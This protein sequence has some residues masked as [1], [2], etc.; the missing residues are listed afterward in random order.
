M[1][2]LRQDIA[3]SLRVLRANPGFTTVAVLT[4]A[5]GIGANAAIFS[6]V[7]AALLRPLPFREPDRLMTASL[8]MPVQYGPRVIDMTWSYP[9]SRTFREVQRAFADLSLHRA[10]ALTVGGADGAERVQG[11]IVEASYFRILGVD[12]AHGRLFA[13]EE[14]TPAGGAP[15]ALISDAYWRRRFS[16]ELGVLGSRI[17]VNGRP[18]TVV[19]VLPRGFRG[20]S[21]NSDL[22]APITSVRSRGVLTGVTTHQ[23][24]MIARLRPLITAGQAKEAVRDAG[25][26]VDERHPD[27]DR[28]RWRAAAYTMSEMRVD[29]AL[30][31]SVLTLGLAVA[32]VLLIACANIANL[33][34][35]RGAARHREIAVRLA[36]GASRGRLVR[37]LLTE[38]AVLAVL[39]AVAGLAVAAIGV[40]VLAASVPASAG[41]LAG[42]VE[43]EH[44]GLTRVALSGI[45]LD[46]SVLLFTLGVTIVTGLLFGLAPAVTASRAPLTD[47]MRQGHVAAPAF[48][49]LR[50]LTGRGALVAAE[51][52]LAVVLLVTAG[53]MIKSLGRLFETHV[54]YDPDGLLTAQVNL[55]NRRYSRDSAAQLWDEIL[56][57]L[58]ALPGV[59][60]VAMGNCSPV[61]DNCDG[62]SIQVAGRTGSS[63]VGL[64]MVSPDYFRT[65][66]V[67][68]LR[69]RVFEP[70]D[71][72]GS[73]R[74]AVVNE[75]AAKQIWAGA[76]PL[77]S[78]IVGWGAAP[79][80][81]VGIVGDM[82][83]EDIEAPARPAMF[84]PYSQ[85][86]RPRGVVFVRS[87]RGDP[88]ALTPAVRQ[89]IR[90][91]DRNHAAYDVRTMRDRM[92]DATARSR[93]STVVLG[94]FAA[95][96]LV[97]ASLGIYGVMSLAVAQRTR[98]LGVRLALGANAR[99][100]LRMVVAQAMALVAVGALVGLG[101][102]VLAARA[103]RSLLYGV[104]PLD[105]W[106]YAG[107]A[108]VLALAALTA[109][110][111][112]ALRAARVSPL[113]A[114]RAE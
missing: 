90:A 101:G 50:R 88:A 7:D 91:V 93:F 67:P 63:H 98:E 33:L 94:T 71:R 15:V 16:A 85:Q 40:R 78:P 41:A 66:R 6:V 79:I 18:F 13:D 12:A 28:G 49:G 61:G 105:A 19:G 106:A 38:T 56:A 3:Y 109:T 53:L 4:L 21:G 89:Q 97:L 58:G 11:E 96:A 68:L 73:E 62:T 51:V 57:R 10:E 111:V 26:L 52:A 35:A 32:L 14:D 29:P 59:A 80:R 39:G 83:F 46:G 103:L 69:G 81:V 8:R 47:A 77:R 95:V 75:A 9:K 64:H 65:L 92:R 20:L 113:E 31:R 60:G 100:L 70:Q 25:R 23:F 110:L 99:D 82:R 114:L 54:G 102:A 48:S 22:W 86:S 108:A 42:V 34:L 87:S 107:S 43:R 72:A 104:A 112:P 24:Q 5:V 1:R 36:V 2:T 84:L 27:T 55:S 45:R 17:D 76:D 30:R 37:Q 44:A 74:V